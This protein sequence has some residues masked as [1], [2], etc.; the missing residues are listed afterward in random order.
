MDE[1]ISQRALAEGRHPMKNVGNIIQWAKD[2]DRI[3]GRKGES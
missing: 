2:P 3:K 1:G